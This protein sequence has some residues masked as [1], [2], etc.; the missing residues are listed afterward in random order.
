MVGWD[1]CDFQ[2]SDVIPIIDKRTTC[3]L[4][5]AKL[6]LGYF[7]STSVVIVRDNLLYYNNFLITNI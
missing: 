5:R 7:M 1:L 6:Q 4:V 3:E 2:Q